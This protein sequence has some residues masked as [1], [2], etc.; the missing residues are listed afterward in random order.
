MEEKQNNIAEEKE[1]DL[2]ALAN[3]IWA[4][5]KFILKAFGVGLVIGLI[6]AFSI[7][8]EYTTTVVLIPDVQTTGASS[9]SSLA[10]LAGINLNNVTNSDILA[11]PEL[12]PD[13]FKS[14]SFLKGLFNIKVKD[15]EQDI[16]TTLYAYIENQE[17]TWWSYILKIPAKVTRSSANF[18]ISDTTKNKRIISKREL[19]IIENLKDRIG[20]SSEKKTGITTIEVVMQSPE[21]SAFVA[22]TLTSYFQSYIIDYRTQKARTDL[23]YA[24]KLY[25]EAKSAYYESQQRLAIFIDG[26][27]NVVSAQYK[28]TQERLQNE[29]NLAYSI[30]NQTAQQLQISRVQVQNTTPVFTIIQPAIQPIKASKPSKKIILLSFIF[31]SSVIGI[32]WILRKDIWKMFL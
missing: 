11:S 25:E 5:R 2:L 31:L 20:V 8:K 6:V 14:T 24:E 12:Y 15:S 23:R 26:N 22:D 21:I 18:N 19:D 29:T 28:T 10:S 3:K 30:Y 7:P 13:I 17:T 32:T 16:D 9:M 4:N 27:M 1:I